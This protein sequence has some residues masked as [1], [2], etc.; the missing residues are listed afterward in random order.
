MIN[1]LEKFIN[2]KQHLRENLPRLIEAFVAFYGEE[3]RKEIEEKFSKAL[4]IAYISPQQKK[5][6]LNQIKDVFSNEIY[7]VLLEKIPSTWTKEDL[8]DGN[9]VEYHNLYP[10]KYFQEFLEQHNLG[11]DGRERIF[12]EKGL[13]SIQM[14]LP[15]FSEEEYE[16]LIQTRTIPEK[17]AEVNNFIKEEMLFYADLS[18]KDNTYRRVFDF[19]K[20]LFE[21]I[22]PNV[23]IENVGQL[24]ENPDIQMLKKY[25][26]LIP[27]II[28]HYEEKM[29][30]FASLEK[31]IE[32]DE[33]LKTQLAKEYNYKFI[34]E[35]IDLLSEEERQKYEIERQKNRSFETIIF[36]YGIQF[37]SPYESFSEEAEKLLNSD[38]YSWKKESII[39]DRI[40]YFNGKG[41]DL[42]NDYADY[43][44]S[45]EAKKI[46]PSFERVRKFIDSKNRLLNE[47]NNVY[48]TSLKEHKE[49]RVEID[50]K[51]LLDKYDGFNAS[52]Y[53]GGI[54]S[55]FVSPNIVATPD[56]FD[57]FSLV[58]IACNRLDGGIDHDI[59][60]ELNHLY[61]LSLCEVKGNYYKT[62]SGWD[63]IEGEFVTQQKMVDTLNKNEEKRDYEL[64]NE[65]INEIIAQEIYL[66]ML[67]RG[68]YIFDTP[69]TA[70]VKGNTSYEHT[71]FLV[72][73]FF[74]EFKEE[75]IASRRND[76]IHIIWDKVG[77]ENF[78]ELNSLFAIFQEHFKGFAVY[79]LLKAL[80]EN[81]DT[82][83]TRIYWDLV[84]RKN[85]IMECMRKHSLGEDTISR[86]T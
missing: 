18:N 28:S 67:E 23:T 46:W 42:G 22:D 81:Q 25:S 20:S 15:D 35:N 45:E 32:E 83:E 30:R 33:K 54:G 37:D 38:A 80:S 7:D 17:Y 8:F 72:R 26:D 31:S 64:F 10:I 4:L 56:G 13:A 61:E 5:A 14:F 78:D 75:I 76:N 48:Y 65:I 1:R 34:D 16:M 53:T 3:K 12:K 68:E 77:K 59:I 55:T 73:E 44:K 63:I 69:K 2:C 85:Q 6:F 39:R 49:T 58:V 29:K 27:T 82:P 47:Y 11:E 70:K 66:K 79:K 41:L 43:L 52:L 60:H 62:T 19:A 21:K 40:R 36:N 57:L 71:F 9:R 84:A 86:A 74:Q 51:Q 24:L 50:A